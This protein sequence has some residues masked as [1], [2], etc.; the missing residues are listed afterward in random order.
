VFAVFQERSLK[1]LLG[2]A[3]SEKLTA[4]AWNREPRQIKTHRRARSAG[5]RSALGKKPAEER[6]LMPALRLLADRVASRLWTKYPPGPT[7]KLILSLLA[8][9]TGLICQRSI[10]CVQLV[11]DDV[12]HVTAI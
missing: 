12:G 1:R 5:A 8:A 3:A 6:V 9:L 10:M 4:P 11:F 2:P 7:V